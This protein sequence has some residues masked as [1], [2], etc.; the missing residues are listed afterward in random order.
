M[1]ERDTFNPSSPGRFYQCTGR[2][3][4]SSSSHLL[5]HFSIPHLPSY[6][7]C[8]LAKMST[9]CASE[10]R[11]SS[12]VLRDV[13]LPIYIVYP[14]ILRPSR[15]QIPERSDRLLMLAMRSDS[16][17]QTGCFCYCRTY[18]DLLKICLSHIAYRPSKSDHLFNGIAFHR[19]VALDLF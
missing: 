2:Y 18:T 15:R 16:R 13:S 17:L 4:A 7:D 9:S 8:F 10:G 12:R 3:S 1:E 5:I 14:Q 19:F 11:M 6:N